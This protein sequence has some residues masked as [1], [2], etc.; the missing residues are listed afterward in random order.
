MSLDVYLTHTRP[1]EVFW[2]N[3]THNC[4]PMAS[5]AGVYEC[6]WRPDEIGITK[7]GQLIE[8]LMSG[9]AAM[10]ADPERFKKLD[11]PNKWGSY[12][13]FLPWLEKYL[14][15]CQE[16]PEADVGVSR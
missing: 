2:A 7:A 4:G 11:P 16:N 9:I 5:E 6:V 8:P 3:Y 14:S 12:D 10:K 15:A 13:T 1:V